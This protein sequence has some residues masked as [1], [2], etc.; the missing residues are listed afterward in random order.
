[1]KLGVITDGISQDAETA[2]RTLKEHGLEYAELQ[3]VYEKEIG[4]QTPEEVKKIKDLISRGRLPISVKNV[5]ALVYTEDEPFKKLLYNR[6]K[7]ADLTVVGFT[8]EQLD[9]MDT[10]VFTQYE[11]LQETLFVCAGEDIL[12]S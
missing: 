12:I 7:T 6:S 11:E 5:K 8:P 10:G 4:E 1:M 3:F 2:F 9:A